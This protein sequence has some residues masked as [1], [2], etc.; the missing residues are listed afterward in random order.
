MNKVK[1]ASIICSG[2]LCCRNYKNYN[3]AKEYSGKADNLR[4]G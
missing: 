2:N 3:N 4:N 1:K